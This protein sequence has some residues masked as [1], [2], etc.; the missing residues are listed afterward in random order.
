MKYRTGTLYNQK[1]AAWF[2]HSISLNCPLCQQLNSALHVVSGCQHIHTHTQ[3]RNMVGS[4][5]VY[6]DVGSSERLAMQTLQI[7]DTAEIRIKA[8]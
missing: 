8:K 7:P 2:K 1:H 3:I 5:S 4:C 6:I